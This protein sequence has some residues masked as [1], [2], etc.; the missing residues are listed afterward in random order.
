MGFGG[1]GGFGANAILQ[2]YRNGVTNT[3]TILFTPTGRINT[4]VGTGTISNP[5]AGEWTTVMID[6]EQQTGKYTVTWRFNCTA[7]CG[8]CSSACVQSGSKTATGILTSF[9]EGPYTFRVGGGDSSSTLRNYANL[10]VSHVLIS[11]NSATTWPTTEELNCTKQESIDK[12]YTSTDSSTDT[13]PN[14][15]LPWRPP[16]CVA[17]PGGTFKSK[18]GDNEC[19]ECTKDHYCPSPSVTPLACPTNSS[20]ADGSA[21]VH[22]CLC[23]E[24]LV[25]VLGEDSY[26]CAECYADTYYTKHQETSLGICASCPA[27]TVSAAGSRS[28]RNCVCKPGFISESPGAYNSYTCTPCSEGTFS[29]TANS[30][31]CDLCVSGKFSSSVGASS[32]AGCTDCPSGTVALQAGMS[33]CVPCPPST[34]QNMAAAGHMSTPCSLCPANS[35]HN[36]SGVSNVFWCTCAPGMYKSPNGTHSFVCSTCEPGFSC[37]ATSVSVV[38]SITL[39]LSLSVEEFSPALQLDFR[40]AIAASVDVDVS[41]VR[42][43]SISEQASSRRLLIMLFRRL[44]SSGIAVEFEITLAS[45]TNVSSVQGPTQEELNQQLVSSGLPEVEILVAPSVVVYNQR[46]LCPEENF[47]AGGE[48]V[49][50]CRLFSKAQPGSSSQEQCMCVPGYYS[51]NT[52]SSCNKCPPGNFCPGGLQVIPCPANAT[53]A[54]GGDSAEAC[55]CE[56]GFWRGCSRTQSGFFR[57]NT[58]HPCIINWT[59]RCFVCGANDICFNDTL[60]HC[61]QHSTSPP[62]SSQPSHCVCYGGFEQLV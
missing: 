53:S 21:S 34:W 43:I 15:F 10:H 36:L 24:G 46:Q 39:G 16:D 1:G 31:R 52:T 57:N 55:F 2:L 54:A 56:P 13:S 18:L 38:M 49:L 22:D 59:E 17:C 11:N 5:W 47:C 8:A 30:S 23:T 28:Q 50:Q 44:L 26:I 60:L 33:A 48:E 42:I 40:E 14:T 6:W 41:R 19:L 12:V 51:L 27:N 61:P 4:N 9:Y 20:S 25:L 35:G 3:E 29:S 45:T 7:A 32:E 62:G 58:G 37:S